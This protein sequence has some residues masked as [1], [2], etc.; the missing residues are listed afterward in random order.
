MAKSKRSREEIFAARRPRCDL[1][2]LSR[3]SRV[4]L[5]RALI[6]PPRLVSSFSGFSFSKSPQQSEVDRRKNELH[7]IANSSC[8]PLLYFRECSERVPFRGL[9]LPSDVPLLQIRSTYLF[10]I[11]FSFILAYALIHKIVIETV[12][13]LFAPANE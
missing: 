4:Y 1:Q 7:R 13:W 2:H 9:L 11:P 10:S 6:S 12:R 3:S 5:E 8:A